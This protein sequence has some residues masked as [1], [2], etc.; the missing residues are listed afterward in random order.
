ME[1]RFRQKL[2]CF[3]FKLKIIRYSLFYRLKRYSQ[4]LNSLS[5]LNLNENS[6]VLDFGANNGV[7]S[8]YLHDRYK[9][10]VFCYE[11]NI[12]CF[13]ILKNIFK[14][15]ENIKFFNVAVSNKSEKKKLYLSNRSDDITNMGLSEISSLEKKKTNV[16]VANFIKVQSLDIEAILSEF[17][18]IDFLKIDIEGHE[19]KILPSIVQNMNKISLIYCEM[20]GKDHRSEFR[21]D[22]LKWDTILKKYENKF[23][24]W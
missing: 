20:H 13:E 9:C 11:P 16:S 2:W 19:Y 17:S 5:E 6:V 15:N 24:Y 8:Q 14:N 4:K 23:Y 22:F 3:L 7:V 1:L 10:K 12:Y 18:K 21:A